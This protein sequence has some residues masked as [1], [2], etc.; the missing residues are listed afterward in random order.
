MINFLLILIINFGISSLQIKPDV[1]VCTNINVKFYSE[2]PI[3]NIE[4]TSI[5]GYSVLNVKNREVQF[6][7]PVNSFKFKKSLMEEHFNE[8]YMES[9]LY[10]FAKFKGKID[11]QIDFQKDGEYLVTVLGE[12]DVHGVKQHRTINGSILVSKGLITVKS[13]FVVKCIDHQIKI[14]KLV[15]KKI[16]ENIEITIKA[17]YTPHISA[18]Q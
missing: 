18:K 3:E 11:Q 1:Y 12:L 9:E 16:A 10:P 7:I 8:N 13:R 14:P 6:N 5:K 15:Y 17:V 2:A 4:A